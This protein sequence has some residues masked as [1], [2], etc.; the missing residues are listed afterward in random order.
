VVSV[1]SHCLLAFFI[2]LGDSIVGVAI[3]AYIKD[4]KIP[5][6][7]LRGSGITPIVLVITSITS[8]IAPIITGVIGVSYGTGTAVGISEPRSIVVSSVSAIIGYSGP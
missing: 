4:W 8:V 6:V 5:S 1:V 7:R 3:I 2:S